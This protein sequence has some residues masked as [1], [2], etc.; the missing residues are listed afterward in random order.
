MTD[1]LDFLSFGILI[2]GYDWLNM[3]LKI[4]LGHKKLDKKNQ[5]KMLS[6]ILAAHLDVTHTT[7]PF[8]LT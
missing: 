6:G 3:I 4:F 1:K 2:S 8:I 7:F 5:N